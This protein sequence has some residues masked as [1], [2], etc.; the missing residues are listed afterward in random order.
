MMFGFSKKAIRPKPA[1]SV[2]S[3][4]PFDM[5]QLEND[6]KRQ[7]KAIEQFSV[8]QEQYKAG[9]VADAIKTYETALNS[10]P[11][12]NCDAH[13]MRLANYYIMAGMYDRAWGYLN[14]LLLSHSNLRPKIR[15]EQI[16]ILKKE[17]KPEEAEQIKQLA[18]QGK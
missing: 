9:N 13:R 17:G 10:V 12:M 1:E 11:K 4:K 15:K 2:A 5:T 7:D 6:L 8:A 18:D 3:A 16:R 14:E